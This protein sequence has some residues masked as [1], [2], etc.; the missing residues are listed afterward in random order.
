M[1]ALTPRSF[2]PLLLLLCGACTIV[3]RSDDEGGKGRGSTGN[4]VADVDLVLDA[5][6]RAASES[7][8]EGYLGLLTPDAVFIGT[9]ASERWSKEEFGDFARPHFEA[10]RGWTYHTLER[11]V[12]VAGSTAWFDERLTNEKYGETR[13]SGVL[14]RQKG[15]W[16]LVQYVLSFPVPN[17]L[18][19]DL[20][21]RIRAR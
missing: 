2:A 7:D 12:S 6:H 3:L 1:I 10:G 8:L 5:F 17:E 14:R 11:H 15:R 13:G 18:A 9:D 4:P 19:G 16:R 20:V 21:E